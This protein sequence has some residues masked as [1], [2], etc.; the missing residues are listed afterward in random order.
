MV[1]WNFDR[2]RPGASSVRELFDED[3]DVAD[4]DEEEED[5][6]DIPPEERILD[7]DEEMANKRVELR[8]AKQREFLARSAEEEAAR[9]EQDYEREELAMQRY[10]D[11]YEAVRVQMDTTAVGQQARLPTLKDPKLFKVKCKTGQEKVAVR[12]I[13]LKTMEQQMRSGDRYYKVKSAFCG[14]TPGYIYVEAVTEALVRDILTGLKMIYT[15]QIPQVPLED[16][17]TVMNVNLKFN[18]IKPG[19]YFRIKRGV[20]KGDLARIVDVF[21]GES[22]AI[23]QAIPRI[24]YH[25]EVTPLVGNK[26]ISADSVVSRPPQALFDVEQANASNNGYVVRRHFPGDSSSIMYDFWN[27]E[28]YRHGFLYKE[29]NV[30]SFIDNRDVN[31]KLEEL[32]R[33]IVKKPEQEDTKKKQSSKKKKANDDDGGEDG[34]KILD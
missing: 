6:Y 32:Q 17:P 20:M 3:V 5:D 25:K 26:K 9:Y 28:Y 7:A 12:A 19:Q 1:Y 8:H 14:S 4:E 2:K 11:D 22:R 29:V 15:W 24:S 13:L 21:E 30:E 23:I 34:D 16:M 18:P 27:G 33:F 31:P 10:G